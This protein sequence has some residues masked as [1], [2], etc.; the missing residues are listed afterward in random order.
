MLVGHQESAIAKVTRNID[1]GGPAGNP[2]AGVRRARANFRHR[3]RATSPAETTT[4][5][6]LGRPVRGQAE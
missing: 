5:G 3:D 6:Q 2:E 4:D 1:G